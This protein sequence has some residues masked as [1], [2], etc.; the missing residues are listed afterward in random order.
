M[1]NNDF[2]IKEFYKQENALNEERG[3]FGELYHGFIRAIASLF[4]INLD[5]M[6]SST[7]TSARESYGSSIEDIIREDPQIVEK[8]KAETDEDGNADL[9]SLDPEKAPD[10][11]SRKAREELRDK[12][13]AKQIPDLIEGAAKEIE[14]IKDL[15]AFFSGIDDKKAKQ[16]EGDDDA[17]EKNKP[18]IESAVNGLGKLLGTCQHIKSKVK[19]FDFKE[20]EKPSP[21]P[22]DLVQQA[23]YYVNLIQPY[24]KENTAELDAIAKFCQSYAQKNNINLRAKFT[25]FY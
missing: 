10:E 23:A 17:L 1:K 5:Q 11:E 22:G 6:S 3:F 2:S 20:L 16:D 14:E 25:L 9:D 24:A 4:N 21:T 15:P 13:I 19:D 18:K 7:F 8:L 12:A